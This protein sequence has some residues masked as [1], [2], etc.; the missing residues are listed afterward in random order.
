MTGV[1]TCALPIC[2]GV[3]G[4]ERSNLAAGQYSVIISDPAVSNCVSIMVVNV[5]SENS[6]MTAAV[7]ITRKATCGAPNGSAAITVTGGSGN[8]SY[9]WG[10]NAVKN[11]LKAGVYDVAVI[12]NTTGCKIIATVNMS[13]ETTTTASILINNKV[14]YTKCDGEAKDRKSTRLNS[15]HLRLSRMPSSA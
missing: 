7:N 5:E 2:D 13:E 12:D 9:S 15:S 14:I 1:Q 10:A 4:F 11:Y 3:V 6:N 8:Y